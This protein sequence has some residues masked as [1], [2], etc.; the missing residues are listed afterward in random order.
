MDQCQ[1]IESFFP[2]AV[3]GKP[4]WGFGEEEK[5]EE[6]QNGRNHLETPRYSESCGTFDKT[7]PVTDVEHDHDTPSNRPLLGTDESA[8]FTWWCQF[9]NVNRNLC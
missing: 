2:T 3:F 4:T 5:A 6:E 1:C 9:G 7:T 8:T